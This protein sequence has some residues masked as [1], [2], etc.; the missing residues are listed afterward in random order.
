MALSKDQ[1]LNLLNDWLAAWNRYDLD[2]V[3]VLIHDDVVFEHWTGEFITGKDKLYRA[4]LPWFRLQGNFTFK[5]EETLVDEPAQKLMFSWLL[6]WNSLEAAYK[7]QREQRRGNDVLSFYE[8][9]IRRKQSYSKTQI[10]IADSQ[11]Q[12]TAAE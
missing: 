2:E 6:E 11:I 7:G 1:L 8:N 4:W 5:L 3:M 10:I 12:L 9:K